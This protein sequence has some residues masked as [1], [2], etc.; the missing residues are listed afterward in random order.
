M[1][2]GASQSDQI[3]NISLALSQYP[4]LSKK[5]RARMR[6]E[7][8]S[9][10]LIDEQGFEK[11][12]KQEAIHSQEREG[13]KD[14]FLEEPAETWEQR[15]QFTRDHLTDL[16]FSKFSNL[17]RF[18]ELVSEVLCEKGI[19]RDDSI[20]S[21]NP[22]LAPQDLLFE[23]ALT[24]E[25][26][27]NE[28][29]LRLDPRLQEIKVVLIRN[30]ISDQLPYINIAKEWFTIA[31]LAEIRKRRIGPGR[32]GGKAAGMLL[33]ARIIK[34]EGERALVENVR[35]PESY[36]IG[37]DLFY[38]FMSINNLV[39]WNDQKYK[40][41]EQMRA[42]YPQI[43]KDFEAST[44][45]PEIIEKLELLLI[46]VGEKPL[47]VRSSSLLE[48]N[49][50][51]SFAGKYES[52][53]CPNQKTL[54]KN[55]KDLSRAISRVYATTLNPDAL[56][57][58]RS[59]GLLDYDERM[60]VLIQG[61]VGE[62][63]GR[64]FMPQASGVAFSRNQ[65]R[66]SPQI[67]TEAGFIRL[68]WG[69]GTRAVDRVG[70]DYPRLIALSHPLLYPSSSIKSMR[71][72]SQQYVDL[73]D[74]EKNKFCTLPVK[75]VLLPDYEGI[76]L[77]TQ[78][79]QD[80]YFQSLHGSLKTKDIPALIFTFEEFLKRTTFVPQ[81]RKILEILEWN[82][83][84]PVDMEF[85]ARLCGKQ[86]N[87]QAVE[88][89]I[90]QCRPQ[91]RLNES[92][93][94]RVPINLDQDDIAFTT[95]FMVPRGYI[96]K[97]RYIIYVPAEEYFKLETVQARN[98]VGRT[99]GKIN[100]KL[101]DDNF[102]CV[103]PGRWGTSNPDLGIYVNYSD[104]YNARALVEITGKGHGAVPEPSLGTHFF[105]D[106][107]EAQIYPLAVNLDDDRAY[108]NTAMFYDSPNRLSDLE[109]PEIPVNSCIRLIDV[110]DY[111]PGS[112]LEISMDDEKGQ[113]VA[114][115]KPNG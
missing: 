53:F 101:K 52:I 2:T 54:R 20:L 62:I 43:V 51:A 77:F 76:R 32:I 94:V 72:Y 36:F 7:L 69:L 58:R 14:P 100:L 73:I 109:D 27:Q 68:V 71:R 4:I 49:F 92:K 114:Y 95:W 93:E 64:Y 74:L 26:Y 75:N 78:L 10:K 21:I 57:Y 84:A 83:R 40:T 24:I 8:F 91:S 13:L 11:E 22:E 105:Q 115:L 112:Q 81:M 89:T 1:T 12:V 30:L 88:I 28:D 63:H 15:V 97:V 37:S 66:W 41:E 60:A 33:A 90:V 25:G 98:D 50:G 23:Q 29:R 6:R 5:I 38:E 44:F 79:E 108:L 39:H 82:Y 106:L 3:L 99:I 111:K 65:F 42:D 67:R 61:V 70:N 56:L 102:I 35:A 104:I 34:S 19:N 31:D 103:G 17:E 47:I 96:Q 85:T 110:T 80:G 87:I 86:E 18:H 107:L 48:D 16:Y 55:L 46:S 9:K 59:R 113:A 45:P